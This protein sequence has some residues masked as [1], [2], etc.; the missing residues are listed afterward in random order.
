MASNVTT[1]DATELV[2]IPYPTK[3]VDDATMEEGVRRV[4]TVGVPGV[5]TLT[6]RVTFIGDRQTDKMLV[7]SVTTKK[8]VGAVVAVGTR[9]SETTQR[10][11]NA[12]YSGC[13]PVAV[14]VDCVGGGN[15]PAYQRS[16]VRVVGIDIYHLDLD[17]DGQACTR[18]NDIP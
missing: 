13:V 12:N 15:G 9:P 3:E 14:D 8:P 18:P 7:G 1:R 6:Y 5:K 11:C 16:P 4:L 17:N 10:D 2:Q